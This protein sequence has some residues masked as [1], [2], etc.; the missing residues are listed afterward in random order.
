MEIRYPLFIILGV[1]IVAAC[2]FVYFLK[3]SKKDFSEGNKIA[4]LDLLKDDP[5]FKKQKKIFKYFN[6]ALVISIAVAFIAASVLMARPYR[7]RRV[8]EEKYCRDI[9]LCL[10]VSTSVD[11]LNENLM[12]ELKDVVE[13]LQGERVGIVIFN[14]SPVLITPLT[15]DYDYVLEQLDTI[16]RALKARLKSMQSGRITSEYYELDA[17]ISGGTLVGNVE[18]GSSLIADGLASC[19][20]DFSEEE[21]DRAKI[22]IFSTDNEPNGDSYVTLEEAAKMCKDADITV[23]GVG[24]KEMKEADLQEMKKAMLITGGGFFLEE[25]SGTFQDI[26]LGIE[27]QSAGKVEGKTYVRAIDL[28]TK[29][30]IYLLFGICAFFVSLKILK[31]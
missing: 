7:T 14:T 9:I 13:E 19:V 25:E 27:D 16:E 29:G 21:S 10:D 28:P 30:F 12:H 31:R 24:T 3:N 18:R 15:D 4:G 26:I 1:G 20:F 23:Y 6:I 8:T 5:Y 2:A 17:F 22:V 11:Y